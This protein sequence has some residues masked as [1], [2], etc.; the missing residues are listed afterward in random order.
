MW[1]REGREGGGDFVDKTFVSSDT[2]IEVR[3]FSG[4]DCISKYIF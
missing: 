3:L 1:K 4:G 2:N